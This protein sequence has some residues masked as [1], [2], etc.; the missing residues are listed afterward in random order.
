MATAL[1]MTRS[2]DTGYQLGR[3]IADGL[4][5]RQ[6]E[7]LLYT[8][9]GFTDRQAAEEM[10]CAPDTV[11]HLR[12]SAHYK[13]GSH[14]GP[15]LVAKAFELGYLRVAALVLAWTIGLGAIGTAPEAM[16]DD[17]DEQQLRFRNRRI[18][19]GRRDQGAIWWDDE[20]GKLVFEGDNQR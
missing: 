20:A 19:T 4:P 2:G 9:N 5:K 16:A 7:A 15:E 6:A 17:H 10:Q 1:H 12:K 3:L 14:T 13:C 18:R 11:K 8:A